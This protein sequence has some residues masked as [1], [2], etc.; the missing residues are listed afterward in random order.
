MKNKTNAG[1]TDDVESRG[2]QRSLELM[3][4]FE[5]KNTLIELARNESR[6]SADAY[7]NAGR[8]NPDWIATEPRDA[9]FLLGLWAMEE[10]TRGIV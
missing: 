4:P 3:S 6:R 2:Y 7:L 5:I 8:G 1:E 9:F 10:A